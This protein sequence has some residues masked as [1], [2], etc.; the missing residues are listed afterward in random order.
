MQRAVSIFLTGIS[1]REG[2]CL[3]ALAVLIPQGKGGEGSTAVGGYVSDK[4][5]DTTS[6]S[7]IKPSKSEDS[8]S[9]S[10]LWAYHIS[11]TQIG[12]SL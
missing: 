12:E 8:K 11:L 7:E 3:V 6:S 9:S 10:L 4:D 2:H 5:K 1:F